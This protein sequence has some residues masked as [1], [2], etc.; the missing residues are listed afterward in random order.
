MHAF[1]EQGSVRAMQTG[2]F[3]EGADV[4]IELIVWFFGNWVHLLIVSCVRVQ[5][6]R[7]YRNPKE[8]VTYHELDGCTSQNR[9]LSFT[10]K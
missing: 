8:A 4:K 2:T 10:S 6:I 7:V 5:R 9:I 1:R 3:D